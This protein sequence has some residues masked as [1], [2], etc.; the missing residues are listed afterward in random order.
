MSELKGWS[1]KLSRYIDMA[2]SRV[3]RFI[4]LFLLPLTFIAFYEVIV[5]YLFSKPTIWAWDINVQLLVVLIVLGG[6][7]TLLEKAHVRLELLTS[8]FS[9]KVNAILE[10]AL[11]PI[12]F[13]ILGAMTWY[14][15]EEALYALR[16]NEVISATFRATVFPTKMI[17]FIGCLLFLAQV[18]SDCIRNIIKLRSRANN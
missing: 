3:G 15:G 4:S 14:S 5:R 10:L 2:N 8:R 7:F 1:F 13:F 11:S 18:F 16:E 12:L 6:P 9:G 17:V